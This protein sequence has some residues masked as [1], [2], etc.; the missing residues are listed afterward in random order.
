LSQI[1]FTAGEINMLALFA[2][3]QKEILHG[4]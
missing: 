1:L 2:N 3:K 4:T